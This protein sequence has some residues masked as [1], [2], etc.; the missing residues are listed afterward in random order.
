MSYPPHSP[1][2]LLDQQPWIEGVLIIIY[3]L[4]RQKAVY[5]SI[6]ILAAVANK[7]PFLAHSNVLSWEEIGCDREKYG[8][9][10]CERTI[11]VI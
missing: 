8:N 7:E 2:S 5:Y 6:M 4:H 3:L 9:R 1:P 10:I 11:S